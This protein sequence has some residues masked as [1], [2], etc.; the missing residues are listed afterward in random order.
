MLNSFPFALIIRKLY[1]YLCVQ[2]S[3]TGI[4]LFFGY[5]I[6]GY[7]EESHLKLRVPKVT[8]DL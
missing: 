1:L 2:C 7:N 4:I 6:F 5:A 8:W 3:Y